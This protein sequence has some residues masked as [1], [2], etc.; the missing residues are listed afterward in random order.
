M[1]AGINAQVLELALTAAGDVSGSECEFLCTCGSLDCDERV[2][3]SPAEY[4][5]LIAAGKRV[6]APVHARRLRAKPFGRVV[7]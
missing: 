2:R 3:L 7:R 5:A 1:L 6:L 4:E